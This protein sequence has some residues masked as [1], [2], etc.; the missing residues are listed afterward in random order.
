[1]IR[2]WLGFIGWSLLAAVGVGLAGQTWLG[3]SAA[4]AVWM[5]TFASLLGAVCGS[6]PLA[7][8]L[9]APSGKSAAAI[10]KATGFRLLVTLG[11]ALV[12]AVAGGWDRKLLLGS[13]AVSYVAL[14]A[15]E[16]GWFL[17]QARK[18]RSTR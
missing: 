13:V 5:G 14:L 15:V 6:L 2:I 3:E 11:V 9:V 16:T 10:G 8:E 17:K 7:A 1:V 18:E 12:A 4:G